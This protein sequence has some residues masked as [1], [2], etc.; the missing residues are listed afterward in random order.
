MI[1][2]LYNTYKMCVGLLSQKVFKDQMKEKAFRR[3]V[4]NATLY[5][6]L[7]FEIFYQPLDDFTDSSTKTLMTLINAKTCI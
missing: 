3:T 7:Y 2:R 1:P 6:F 5:C 4:A